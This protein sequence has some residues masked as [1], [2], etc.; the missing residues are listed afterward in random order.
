MPAMTAD[1]IVD[2]VRDLCTNPPFSFV[3]AVTW[4]SFDQQPTTNADGVFRIPP[5]ASSRVRGQFDFVEDRIDQMQI[6]LARKHNQDY[7]AVRRQLLQDMHALTAAVIR[8]AHQVSGDYGIPDEGR[9]H[10]IQPE[11]PN[12]EYVTLRLTLPIQYE[13]AL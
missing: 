1:L 5:L 13:A 2:R 3:E 7:D 8:D 12:G 10:A 11:V 9:G 6:W 4:S